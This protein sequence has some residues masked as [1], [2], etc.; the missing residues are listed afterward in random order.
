MAATVA[1]ATAMMARD[2]TMTMATGHMPTPTVPTMMRMKAARAAPL[3]AEE[4]EKLPMPTVN[5][6][7]MPQPAIPMVLW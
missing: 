7:A 6:A 2:A 5:K 4:K 1:T 3:T